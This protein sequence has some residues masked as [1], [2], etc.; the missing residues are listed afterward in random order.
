MSSGYRNL[1]EFPRLSLVEERRLIARAKRGCR[2][3][4]DELVCRHIG[5]VAFRIHRRAFRNFRERY[6]DDILS[7]IVFI[8]YDKIRTYDLR[9]KDEQGNPRPVRFTSYIWKRVDGFILDF[10][11]KVSDRERRRVTADWERFD[12]GRT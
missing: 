6:G 9:Y 8:L 12:A 1:P 3:D 5:F 2:R 4:I 11:R 10:L 7:E